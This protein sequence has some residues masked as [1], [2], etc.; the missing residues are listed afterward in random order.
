MQILSRAEFATKFAETEAALHSDVWRNYS[1]SFSVPPHVGVRTSLA[2]RL[3]GIAITRGGGTLIVEATGVFLSCENNY[4]VA[5]FRRALGEGRTVDEAPVHVFAPNDHNVCWSLICL[6]LY[7]FWDFSLLSGDRALLVFGSHDEYI[8][9][10]ALNEPDLRTFGDAMLAL[11]ITEL[12]PATKERDE[13]ARERSVALDRLRGTAASNPE[14]EA[15]Q[16]KFAEALYD[17][18]SNGGNGNLLQELRDLVA[19]HPGQPK[20]RERLGSSF[21]SS[22]FYARE[23]EDWGR[24]R[25]LLEELRQL[26]IGHPEDAA[27]RGSLAMALSYVFASSAP[28]DNQGVRDELRELAARYPEDTAVREWLAST[29]PGSTD[30]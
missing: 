29:E 16:E 12:Q 28:A 17:E 6:C 13:K 19:G 5:T 15:V 20:L 21:Y 4:L 18:I 30:S 9:V 14:D 7:N 2:G 24:S 1:S 23:D 10:H 27:V 25:E 22:L 11:N 26:A 3:A 8:D